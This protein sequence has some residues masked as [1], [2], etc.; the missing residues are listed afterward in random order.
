MPFSMLRA[1][2][3]PNTCSAGTVNNRAS[4]QWT[5]L[6]FL[7]IQLQESQSQKACGIYQ[8]QTSVVLCGLNNTHWTA[9]AFRDV[10]YDEEDPE[11]EIEAQGGVK[12]DPIVSSSAKPIDANQPV[13]D[14]REYFLMAV[15]LGVVRAQEEYA[16]LVRKV[17]LSIK[18]YVRLLD[19]LL[20]SLGRV[21]TNTLTSEISMLAISQHKL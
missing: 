10:A 13:W 7:N 15:K 4:R 16:Y 1:L 8:A 2:P 20:L 18:S 17:T 14:P 5:D 11:A 19:F 3:L 9:Y 21:I 6:S 12:E